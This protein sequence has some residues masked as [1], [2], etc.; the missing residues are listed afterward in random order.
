[1]SLT[2]DA[3]EYLGQLI[4]LRTLFIE[5]G[6]FSGFGISHLRPLNNLEELHLNGIIDFTDEGIGY[7]SKLDSLRK[8]SLQMTDLTS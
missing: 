3:F 4:N 2:D 7:I 6:Q 5:F 8:L 1:M